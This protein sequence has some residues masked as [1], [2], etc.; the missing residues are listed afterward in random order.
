M[1]RYNE[2]D[3]SKVNT[4]SLFARHSKVD[5]GGFAKPSKKNAKFS[6]FY[7]NLPG[8][9]VADSFKSVVDAIVS[10]KKHKKAV[11][12]MMGAHVIKVGLSPLVIDLMK[13]GVITA[14]SLNGAGMIHD[15]EISLAGKTSEEVSDGIKDGSFGMARE[16]A[17]F[18]NSALKKGRKSGYGAGRSVGEAIYRS[19]APY[20][21]LSILATGYKE[22]VP[23]TVHIA[24]GTDIVHQQP[25]SD[26]AII[27]EASYKD[28]KNLIYTVSGLNGG[29]VL[30]NFG[31]SVIMPEVFLKA[32][33]TARNLYK[34]VKDFTTVNF[35]MI[36]HYRPNVNIVK[37][38]V[39][40]GGRGIEIRGHHEIMMPLLYQ[41]ILEKL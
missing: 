17:E 21:N 29:G 9:L 11:I 32:L 27:G 35:D 4:Y 26:G 8:F 34:K 25:S 7:K 30:I 15:T 13:K 3:L 16:T 23:V 33:T 41:A 19:K 40:C 38:P 24:I 20:K 12:L 6:D 28:F 31:S 1:N 39:S 10:A 37:R 5:L 2:A 36:S 22:K 14:V 18:I